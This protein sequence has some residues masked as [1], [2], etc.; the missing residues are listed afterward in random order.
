MKYL[1]YSLPRSGLGHIVRA[2]T[3]QIF[4]PLICF[5]HTSH[6]PQSLASCF[7]VIRLAQRKAGIHLSLCRVASAHLL[8]KHPQFLPFATQNHLPAPSPSPFQ[9]QLPFPP[10]EPPVLGAQ[11]ELQRP[12]LSLSAS[13]RPK[14]SQAGAGMATALRSTAKDRSSCEN[15]PLGHRYSTLFRME[16]CVPLNQFYPAHGHPETSLN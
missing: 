1:A 5:R 2:Q 7:H 13:R 15:L 8:S 6:K 12:L 14:P 10:G 16:P 3:S 4:F 9:L 11:V